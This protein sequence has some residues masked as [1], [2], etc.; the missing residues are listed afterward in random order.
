MKKWRDYYD[1]CKQ[2]YGNSSADL[3]DLTISINKPGEENIF[4]FDDRYTKTVDTL[5]EKLEHH[6]TQPGSYSMKNI[7]MGVN[8]IFVFEDEL[9]TMIDD[10]ITPALEEKVFGSYVT[11]DNIKMY[12]TPE[13]D[14]REAS[15]WLWHLD[16]NPAEQIKVMVY[17]NDVNKDSG[18]FRWLEQEDGSGIKLTPSRRDFSYWYEGIELEKFQARGVQWN[19]TRLQ[20]NLIQHWMNEGCKIHDVEAP[21]GTAIVFDNNIV[22]KGTIP[23]NGYR[24]A[25]TLQFKPIDIK[26]PKFSRDYVGNGWNHKT[27]HMDPQIHAPVPM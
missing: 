2:A 5:R 13:T 22:H 20:N 12:K 16:N 21:A 23:T 1:E 9:A 26:S 8:D 18:A 17:I 11:C 24:L 27:F 10:Y 25:M 3:K 7:A 6:L 19:G 14:A 15:S 4:N